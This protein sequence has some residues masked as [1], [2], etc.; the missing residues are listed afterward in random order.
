M[1]ISFSIILP[2]PQKSTKVSGLAPQRNSF[3]GG[4]PAN[5][6]LAEASFLLAGLPGLE[7]G[8]NGFG[9]RHSTN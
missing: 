8:T 5:K 4:L 3:C 6:K 2:H 7:P 9:N 1:L